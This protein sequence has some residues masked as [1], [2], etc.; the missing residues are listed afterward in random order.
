MKR[1]LITL[2]SIALV[3][4]VSAPARAGA[5]AGLSATRQATPRAATVRF[6]PRL[7]RQSSKRLRFT[8]KARYPQAAGAA[9]D[10]RLTRMNQELA[11]FVTRE[12]A[13]FRSYF[14]TPGERYGP[15]GSYYESDYVVTLATN[16]VVSVAFG[17][18]TYGEGAA[19][20]NHTTL[21]FNYDL[22]TGRKLGLPDLFK[23]G[24][25]YLEVISQYAVKQLKDELQPEPG[26]DWIEQGAG[27][28]LENYKRWNISPKGLEVTFDPYEVASYAEGIHEVV[29]PFSV[30]KEVIDP[31]GPLGRIQN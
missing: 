17:I 2:V 28:K 9:R 14:K 3:S 25:N 10:R 7:I 1:F 30:L 19:H 6:V 31:N 24:S 27:P 5:G 18:S 15:T 16:D 26:D 23:P 20:P 29:I 13:E 8:I 21:V 4:G 11:R 22:A 12:V